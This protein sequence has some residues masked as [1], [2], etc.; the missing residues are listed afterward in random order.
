MREALLQRATQI[1]VVHNHPS[2][3]RMPGEADK[4]MTK[5]LAEAAR[6][7]DIML[8]DHLVVAGDTYFSFA[9]EGLL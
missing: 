9:D 1:V 3:N 4:V 5:K 8:L 6:L 7:C 2:G